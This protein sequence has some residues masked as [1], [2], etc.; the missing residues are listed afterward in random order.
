MTVAVL[1]LRNQIRPI[2]QLAI[3][4][5]AF[6]KGRDV[7]NFRPRG[8]RE[9]RQAASTFIEMRRRVERSIEQRT[10]MLNG[11][12]HDLRTI[13]T[14]F[15]LSLA[16]LDDDN[17]ELEALQKDVDEMSRMLEAYLAFARG[18]AGGAR[19]ADQHRRPPRGAARRCAAARPRDQ[20]VVRR[21]HR[22]W[23]C[24]PTPSSGA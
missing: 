24:A 18:D 2:Q 12:S 3:A 13:L 11:V 6:G 15:K 14:R 20:G 4:A 22:S 8:A 21:E 9:V 19:R 17:P 5:E 7:A 10:T 16:V 1:F 23:W